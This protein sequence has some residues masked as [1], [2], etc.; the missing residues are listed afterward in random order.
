MQLWNAAADSDGKITVREITN[1]T[2]P[3]IADSV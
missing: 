1:G 3:L 2:N